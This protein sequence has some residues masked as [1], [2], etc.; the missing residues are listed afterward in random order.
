[1]NTPLH[2]CGKFAQHPETAKLLI[3][4]GAKVNFQ[5]KYGYTP[6]HQAASNDDPS[7]SRILLENGADPNIKD[8]FGRAPLHKAVEMDR[9]NSA[10]LLIEHPETDINAQTNDNITALHQ[11]SNYGYLE[12]CRLLVEHG[13]I[14]DLK[15][16][17][18]QTALE[19]AEEKRKNEI[20]K[21]L[22]EAKNYATH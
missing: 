4:H 10:K 1:M 22:K 6:L 11:C 2:N 8:R 9:R 5:N 21:L 17:Y 14:L 16:N 13:A 3:K 18:G 15:N 7:V 19:I 20:I 12:I